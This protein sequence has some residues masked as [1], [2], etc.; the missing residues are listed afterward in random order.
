[1]KIFKKFQFME[2]VKLEIF[3]DGKKILEIN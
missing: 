3:E 2:S 1:M